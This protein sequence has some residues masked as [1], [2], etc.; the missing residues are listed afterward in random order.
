MSSYPSPIIQ[1]QNV[2]CKIYPFK[3]SW[4]NI[5]SMSTHFYSTIAL[6]HLYSPWTSLKMQISFYMLSWEMVKT[7]LYWSNSSYPP[8]QMTFL[9]LFKLGYPYINDIMFNPTKYVNGSFVHLKKNSVEDRS[10]KRK[11]W[12]KKL[13]EYLIRP[14][15]L[16]RSFI[17]NLKTHKECKQQCNF[18]RP[19]I[20]LDICI[21]I[22][23]K[24]TCEWYHYII[25]LTL[26][27]AW[28]L[29]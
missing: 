19:L 12:L 14:I 22:D 16:H 13:I 18:K 9:A 23:R 29:T 17:Y 11:R 4:S 28:T 3:C 7:I 26:F 21:L 25:R 6:V 15:N 20:C 10:L 8:L 27:L 5:F 2:N 24:I 1:L